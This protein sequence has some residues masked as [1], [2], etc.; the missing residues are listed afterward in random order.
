MPNSSPHDDANKCCPARGIVK[1]RKP[2][3]FSLKIVKRSAEVSRKIDSSELRPLEV[4]FFNLTACFLLGGL[5]ILSCQRTQ[6]NLSVDSI[7]KKILTHRSKN[8]ESALKIL[9]SELKT[10]FTLKFDSDSMQG[11][12]PAHPRA[13]LSNAEGTLYMS[14]NGHSEQE[15]FNSLEFLEYKNGEVLL[16]SLRF[17]P[18]GKKLPT[19][20]QPGPQD[21]CLSC[22]RGID[23]TIIPLWEP[24]V[25]TR[26]EEMDVE[27]AYRGYRA[28][29]AFTQNPEALKQ[30]KNLQDFLKSA[31]QH[32]RYKQL[33]H[34]VSSYKIN[35]HDD[36]SANLHNTL[37]NY[38][39]QRLMADQL[40]RTLIKRPN[41]EAMK[42]DLLGAAL[43]CKD[44]QAPVDFRSLTSEIHM[45]N[46]EIK[47]RFA[48]NPL[49]ARFFNTEILAAYLALYD[50]RLQPLLPV[51][52]ISPGQAPQAFFEVAKL[53]VS[54]LQMSDQIGALPPIPVLKSLFQEGRF[55][56]DH[57]PL[58]N[59]LKAAN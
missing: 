29:K 58:C 23:Q 31:P 30:E 55:L 35:S 42:F 24:Y 22:H 25:G 57:S 38:R 9:P 5:C 12:S 4:R 10:Y 49:G 13:I 59:T 28:D 1:L 37:M 48:Q 3:K 40:A 8:I 50:P 16:S 51:L 36:Q 14:F 11:A 53:R 7:Y 46:V 54:S 19:L 43:G 15:D 18:E 2:Q 21:S 6:K 39:I 47:D 17:D 33:T 56:Q 52:W 41:Y 34:L 20:F 26:G 44:F 27:G 45:V 32:P